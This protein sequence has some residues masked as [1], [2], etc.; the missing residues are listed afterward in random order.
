MR[1]VRDIA[2]IVAAVLAVAVLVGQGF[3]FL[4]PVDRLAV[5]VLAL[6]VAVLALVLVLVVARFDRG[7]A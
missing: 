1:V 5:A 4:G 3:G 6:V 7:G 2:L